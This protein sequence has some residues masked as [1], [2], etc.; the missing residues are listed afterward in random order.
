MKMF[1]SENEPEEFVWAISILSL[2]QPGN[3]LP[4]NCKWDITP[5]QLRVLFV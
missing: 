2:T 3:A 1:F 5:T 4:S